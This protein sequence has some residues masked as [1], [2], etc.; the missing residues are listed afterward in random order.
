MHFNRRAIRVLALISALGCS[1]G[2]GEADNGGTGGSD[3]DFTTFEWTEL[4]AD[5]PWS[6]RA[7]LHTVELAGKFYLMGGRTPTD[8]MGAPFPP[9][10][11]WADVWVSDDEGVTWEQILS[12]DTP[13]HWA[14][15]AYFQ[16]VVKG[17]AMY[18][19]GGQDF[20][21]PTSNFYSD[22]WSSE[23]GVVWT[24]RTADAG[25]EPR[26]GLRAVTFEDEIYIFGGSQFDD[27]AILPGPTGPARIYYNDVW[28]SAD[29]ATWEEMT[30]NAPW[31]PR[32][33]A[34]VVVKD[35][36]MYLLGGE[37]GFLCD[38]NADPDCELPYFNDVWRSQDGADWELV[39]DSAGWSPRPGHQCAVSF[40]HIVC[41]GGFG[42][43]TN[44]MDVWVS[45]DGASWEQVSDSPWNAESPD[46][47]KYDF[48]GI[49]VG[50]V[51]YTFG[52]DR[53]TFDFSDPSNYLRVD[54][55]VWRYTL[56]AP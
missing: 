45:P 16:T 27:S 30:A 25:W 21:F 12:N 38:T 39:T 9:A 51:I 3:A 49:A 24:E 26:A 46:E 53:E 36:Y 56:P 15:R 28:K 31:E 5:A 7:G 14:P 44:P 37:A 54:N 6:R 18:V 1:S 43:P 2:G 20:G 47:I 10:D 34:V 22:V 41:W 55:D 48:E 35:D 8:P 29:G 19:L 17:N 33:G 50:D 32:A 13:G 52:G 42:L 11:F 40:D 23:D 4:N